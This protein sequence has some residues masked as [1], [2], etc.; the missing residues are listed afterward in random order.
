MLPWK[1]LK[2]PGP[3]EVMPGEVAKAKARSGASGIA[4]EL[5]KQ[6]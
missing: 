6:K 5:K 2:K 4:T 1:D 3:G